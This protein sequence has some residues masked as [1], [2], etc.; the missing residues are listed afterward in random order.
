MAQYT[1]TITV[2]FT[3]CSFTYSATKLKAS[4]KT[5]VGGHKLHVHPNDKVSWTCADDNF[6]GL[7]KSDS[8]LE[9]AGFAGLA[10]DT[11]G[12]FKVTAKYKPGESNT[13][14]YF[15]AAINPLDGS[16]CT[17]DPDIIIDT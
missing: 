7:F 1:V 8:P 2:D 13:Y 5:R 9:V 17:D 16:T 6:C 3:D 10:G 12:P 14:S 4:K 15:V 11:A